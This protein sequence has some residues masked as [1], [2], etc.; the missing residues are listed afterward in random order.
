MEEVL[1]LTHLDGPLEIGRPY[2]RLYFGNEFCERLLPNV[3]TLKRALDLSDRSQVSFSLVTPFLTEAGMKRLSPLLRLLEEERPD[4][5]IV[6][7][8]WGLLQ[9]LGAAT[10]APPFALVIGRLLTKQARDPRLTQSEAA[11][12][13]GA[14]DHFRRSNVDVPIVTDFLLARHVTRVEFDNPFHGLE[15]D[16]PRLPASL[17]SPYVYLTTSRL[18]TFN[19]RS[20]PG[21]TGR[22]VMSCNQECRGQAS[23]LRHKRM[24]VDLLRKGNTIF[25]RNDSLP[26]N[27]E[28]LNI[29]RVI[30]QPEIPV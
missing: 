1:H 20:R 5:E 16:A 26:S 19:P 11:L 14:L 4:S 25:F 2:E 8:D 15:R 23:R 10:T 29:D 18:C 21:E 7:N 27:L 22:V 6:I 3:E 13:P 24:P 17:Y 12:S 30:R 9:L 28:A